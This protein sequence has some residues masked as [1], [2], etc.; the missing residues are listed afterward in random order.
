MDQDEMLH[1]LETKAA[2]SRLGSYLSEIQ[3]EGKGTAPEQS[4]TNWE[5]HLFLVRHI[6]FTLSRVITVQA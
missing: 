2:A 6:L 1:L 4:S 5:L 3:Y